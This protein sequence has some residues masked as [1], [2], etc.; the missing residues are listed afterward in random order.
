MDCR[1]DRVN[2]PLQAEDRFERVDV[3]FAE[4][5]EVEVDAAQCGLVQP[6]HFCPAGNAVLVANAV[7]RA[8]HGQTSQS[9]VTNGR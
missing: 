8:D 3:E 5:G 6:S 4:A 9:D 2:A 1:R 7:C